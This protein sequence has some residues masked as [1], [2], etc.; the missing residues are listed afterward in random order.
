[1]RIIKAKAT[2][3]KMNPTQE[4][5]E[6]IEMAAR[7]C[8]KSEEKI[9]QGSA[10]TLLRNIVKTGH[11]SVIEHEVATVKFVCDRG[12]MLELTRHRLNSFSVESTRYCNFS[13]DKFDNEI[14]VIR[15]FFYEEGT[16]EFEVWKG[17]MLYCEQEYLW[18][19]GNGSSPQKARSVLPNSLKTEV[20]MT[21]NLRQWRTVFN[22]RCSL[23]AHP[24]MRELTLPLLEEFYKRVP[25]LFEDI[26]K[27]YIVEE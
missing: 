27:K 22:Q 21:C 15:P 19:I 23:K 1:L 24:Q 25:V 16:S 11:E 3:V 4:I 8:Y 14:T 20:V 10:E 12:I 17:V 5:M 18:L 13:K 6:H 7:T 26:Y 9:K 2:I